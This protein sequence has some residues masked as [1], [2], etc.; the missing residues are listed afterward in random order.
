MSLSLKQWTVDNVHTAGSPECFFVASFN[1]P[2]YASDS[3]WGHTEEEMSSE[4]W[5]ALSNAVFIAQD[6]QMVL[7]IVVKMTRKGDLEL[8]EA[9]EALTSEGSE[10]ED[11]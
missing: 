9:L 8:V 6:A 2:K 4:S 11:G 3:A 7:G 5:K 1:F 10:D